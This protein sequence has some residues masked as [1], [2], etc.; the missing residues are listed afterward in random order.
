MISSKKAFGGMRHITGFSFFSSCS[1]FNQQLSEGDKSQRPNVHPQLYHFRTN[2]RHHVQDNNR[3]TN[4]DLSRII[5]IH[6]SGHQRGSQVRLGWKGIWLLP[7]RRTSTRC[8]R[9]E[10]CIEG[11]RQLEWCVG[12][13]RWRLRR[14]RHGRWNAL[15]TVST[16]VCHWFG[17]AELVW[18]A[19]N[20]T[21]H[22]FSLALF[23]AF[24]F[25][26]NIFYSE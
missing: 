2:Q 23:D 20:E 4:N 25:G 17:G 10:E 5:G 9:D 22:I 11:I 19:I 7:Q 14:V 15:E 12:W 1:L 13:I 21:V 6:L 18:W 3:H 24:P 8:H 16:S 26:Y